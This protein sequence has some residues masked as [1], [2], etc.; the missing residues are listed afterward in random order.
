MAPPLRALD[1]LSTGCASAASGARLRSLLGRGPFRSLC[2]RSWPLT[3]RDFEVRMFGG[4]RSPDDLEGNLLFVA[5]S[6][7]LHLDRHLAPWLERDAV[8][9][10]LEL[11]RALPQPLD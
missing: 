2:G 7:G 5:L 10:L 4:F 6:G 1:A 9:P 11:D 3:R 8:L